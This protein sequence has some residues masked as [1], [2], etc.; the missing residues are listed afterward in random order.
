MKF[1]SYFRF[2]LLRIRCLNEFVRPG[3]SEHVRI[4]AAHSQLPDAFG[5]SVNKRFLL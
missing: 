3:K 5:Y 4:A 2:S 1:T